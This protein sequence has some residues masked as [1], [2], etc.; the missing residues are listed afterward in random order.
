MAVQAPSV[1]HLTQCARVSL[2]LSVSPCPFSFGVSYHIIPYSYFSR[3][4]FLATRSGV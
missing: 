4:F 1:I 3:A 2:C